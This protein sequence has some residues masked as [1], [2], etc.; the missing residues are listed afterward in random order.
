MKMHFILAVATV[1]TAFTV[2]AHAGF[3]DGN[4]LYETCSAKSGRDIGLCVGYITGVADTLEDAKCFTAG[5][6]SHQVY[7]AVKQ[8]LER[9]PAERHNRASSL[10]KEAIQQAFCH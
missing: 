2:P 6:D 5:V 1:A 9:H 4:K 8:Y 7:D 10:V 3:Y